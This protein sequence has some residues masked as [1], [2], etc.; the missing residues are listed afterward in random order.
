LSHNQILSVTLQ[1][2]MSG[3]ELTIQTPAMA[4]IAKL[5]NL[6]CDPNTINVQSHEE[7]DDVIVKFCGDNP[8][9]LMTTCWGNSIESSSHIPHNQYLEFRNLILDQQKIQHWPMTVVSAYLEGGFF[10][11]Y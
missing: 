10:K 3:E 8:K 6:S 4:D 7:F 9:F 11:R 2:R 1:N 5:Q